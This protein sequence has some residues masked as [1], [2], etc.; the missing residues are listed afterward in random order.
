VGRNLIFTCSKE[1]KSKPKLGLRWIDA[2]EAFPDGIDDRSGLCHGWYEVASDGD[3][4]V[5][6][7]VREG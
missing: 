1:Q 2:K 7:A 4:R 3:A 6:G 5:I